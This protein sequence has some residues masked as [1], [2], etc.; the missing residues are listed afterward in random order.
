LEELFGEWIVAM[1][2]ED[3]PG[4]LLYH[5]INIGKRITKPG[6]I[7][8]IC[9]VALPP[10]TGIQINGFW[11]IGAGTIIAASLIKRHRQAAI[12][13]MHLNRS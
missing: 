8:N 4:F 9:L 11:A 10:L 12:A 1:L 5:E 13:V 2:L 6:K 3:Q 7:A